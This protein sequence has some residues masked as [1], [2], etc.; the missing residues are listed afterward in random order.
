M[1][2]RV[3]PPPPTRAQGRLQQMAAVSTGEKAGI[4]VDRER[5]AQAVRELAADLATT[6]RD[7]RDKQRRIDS[8]QAEIASLLATA[9][10]ATRNQRSAHQGSSSQGWG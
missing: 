10:A 2:Q 9:S 3:V 4:A 6:R 5:L 7:C 1:A 8:L